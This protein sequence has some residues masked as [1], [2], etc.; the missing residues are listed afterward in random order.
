MKHSTSIFWSRGI[1]VITTAQLH[2]SKLELRFM[3]SFSNTTWDVSEIRS[4]EDLC[5]WSWL[6][7]RLSSFR[8]STIPQKQFIKTVS[9]SFSSVFVIDFQRMF[10][11]CEVN[12]QNG[13]S[14]RKNRENQI[15]VF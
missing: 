4:G 6:E 13:I 11:H 1:V 3:S 14:G 9:M 12:F 2:S 7:I 8:L 15:L 10:F 5:Q